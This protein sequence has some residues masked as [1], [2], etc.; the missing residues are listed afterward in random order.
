M[1]V[2]GQGKATDSVFSSIGYTVLQDLRTMD[3]E[4]RQ[5]RGLGRYKVLTRI[6]VLLAKNYP[7]FLAAFEIL[8]HLRA[9]PGFR[10]VLHNRGFGKS[11][12]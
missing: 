9:L 11:L 6:I 3:N 5:E 1:D 7:R 8:T 12:R 2:V 10:L 4:L